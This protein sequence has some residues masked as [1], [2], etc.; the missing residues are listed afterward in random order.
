MRKLLPISLLL[1]LFFFVPTVF[2]KQDP[3]QQAEVDVSIEHSET[4]SPV[5]L[6]DPPDEDGDYPVPG[7]KYLRLR[8]IAHPKK[9][10][11]GRKPTPIQ[12]QA[13]TPDNDQ[14]TQVNLAGWHLKP[15][16]TTYRVSYLTVPSSVGNAAAKTAIANAF[17]TWD[18][19]INSVS[20]IEGVAGTASRSRFDGQNAVLWRRQSLSTLAIAYTWYNTLT[21]EAVE[22]D[23][24]FNARQ[25]WSFTP[26]SSA[27]SGLDSYDVQ[28]IATHEA[29]H[30][31]GLDDMYGIGDRDLTMYGYGDKNELKKD[32]L[33]TGDLSAIAALYN[34]P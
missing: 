22:T 3:K 19:N 14:S 8:V 27:C 26:Y 16:Q 21:K 12:Q 25:K 20:F 34:S 28:N 23:L 5:I 30:W 32:T 1:F 15:G 2:A 13:C 11:E 7:K 9:P 33:T 6:P 31:A 10:K 18:T 4:S 29:G 24:V 17:S